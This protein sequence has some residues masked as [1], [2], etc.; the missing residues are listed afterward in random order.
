MRRR[1]LL[2]VSAALLAAC[3]TTT[4]ITD[5]TDRS[6][7]YGWLNIKDVE[8]NRLTDRA[9]AVVTVLAALFHILLA[10][11]PK[12]SR[13]I[14]FSVGIDGVR[15]KEEVLGMLAW[16]RRLMESPENPCDT[17][18]KGK[19]EAATRD[20]EELLAVWDGNGAPPD[21]MVAWAS[22]FLASWDAGE[23]G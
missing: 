4:R 11:M 17:A 8:A 10:L 9:M 16:I 3:G 20:L 6:V 23:T 13:A 1:M 14:S 18:T 5:F 15:H 19:L 7:G 22:S 2:L 12:K 21:A